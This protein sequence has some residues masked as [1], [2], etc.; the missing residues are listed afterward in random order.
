MSPF[1]S[2]LKPRHVDGLTG[3]SAQVQ[4]QAQRLGT[5]ASEK[6][7]ITPGQPRA[8]GF[9]Q[10]ELRRSRNANQEED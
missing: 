2:A 7:R 9:W 1:E 4:A 8:R 10:G 6:K 5:I 3:R